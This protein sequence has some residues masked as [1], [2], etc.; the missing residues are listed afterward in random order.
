MDMHFLNV[1]HAAS[2]YTAYSTISLCKETKMRQ[3]VTD[4]NHIAEKQRA[5]CCLTET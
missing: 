3:G 1:G 4:S 2:G 5:K